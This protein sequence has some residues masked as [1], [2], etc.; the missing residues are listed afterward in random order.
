MTDDQIARL[1]AE[2]AT[3]EAQLE[4]LQGVAGA[5]AALRPLLEERRRTLAALERGAPLPSSVTWSVTRPA[6]P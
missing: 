3:L 6:D 2:I 5:A 4:A 1:S